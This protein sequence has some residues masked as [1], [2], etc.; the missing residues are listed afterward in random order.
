MVTN[1]I[2]QLSI[3]S[4]YNSAELFET[5]INPLNPK[6]GQILFYGLPDLPEIPETEDDTFIP[7]KE[8]DL[9]RL[10]LVSEEAAGYNTPELWWI[11]ARANNILDLFDDSLI[12]T[13]LRLPAMYSVFETLGIITDKAE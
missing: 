8:R 10:D 12:T 4:R 11:I 6:E 7:L 13:S 5:D 1:N 9:G 3:N 2:R